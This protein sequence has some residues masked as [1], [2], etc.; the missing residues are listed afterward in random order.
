MW[1]DYFSLSNQLIR[2]QSMSTLQNQ[3][4]SLITRRCI[5]NFFLFERLLLF[6]KY[7]QIYL[8]HY[9]LSHIL[10]NIK[11]YIHFLKMC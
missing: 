5:L 2:Y 4:I 10:M 7:C 6:D 8:L 9:F 3:M 11:T 1:T